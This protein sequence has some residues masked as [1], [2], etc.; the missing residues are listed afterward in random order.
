MDKK[1]IPQE[2]SFDPEQI[3]ILG[4]VRDSN[5]LSYL[6]SALEKGSH[7]S[8]VEAAISLMKLGDSSGE[9]RLLQIVKST[10]E[11]ILNRTIALRGL[12]RL[13]LMGIQFF[14][15]LYR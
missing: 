14:V 10:D 7:K 13:S 1:A 6:Q 8:V 2:L 12:I 9:E 3:E 5:A 11:S 15:L 4:A